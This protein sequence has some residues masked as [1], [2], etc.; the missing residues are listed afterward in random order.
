MKNGTSLILL[1]ISVA[2][3]YVFVDPQ[4]QKVKVLSSEASEYRS[5]IDN[6]NDLT[7]KR[8]A[9]LEKLQS[10]NKTEVTRLGKVLP[11]HV[12]AVRLAMDF[13]AIAA[14]YGISI[15][16][17]RV[18]ND[19]K[20]NTTTVIDTSLSR[21]YKKVNITFEFI[22]T[23]ENFRKFMRDIEQSLRIIDIRSINFVTNDTNFSE[24]EVSIDTY[25]LK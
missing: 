17:I 9:L 22:A 2:L 16:N 14:K 12:D 10:L 21:P 19:K 8:D 15:K 23:Y 18:T 13:D 6:V 4:Y 1:V 7:D 20:E 24:Y 5:V 3:F 11:D 25:W